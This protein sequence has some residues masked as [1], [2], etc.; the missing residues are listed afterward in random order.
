MQKLNYIILI[1]TFVFNCKGQDTAIYFNKALSKN[2]I[3]GSLGGESVS[4]GA[5]YE[6]CFYSK[7]NLRINF[8]CKIGLASRAWFVF[9]TG[10]LGEIFKQKNKLL[11]GVFLGN[12]FS[13]TA[14]NYTMKD[15]KAIENNP[16]PL[17]TAVR[18]FYAPYGAVTLGYKRYFNTKNAIS[19]YANGGAY[20][21]FEQY[22]VGSTLKA[23]LRTYYTP[24][25]GIT[26]H[27]QF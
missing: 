6:R 4:I 3:T 22:F 26:Y 25:A 16:S 23:R 7:K 15:V 9:P 8:S 19:I 24:F 20:L 2:A 27:R 5:G 13:P 18:F 17:K 10:F 14:R 12:S 21:G 1:V 11:F